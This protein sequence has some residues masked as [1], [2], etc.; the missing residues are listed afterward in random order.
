MDFILSAIPLERM[1]IG[2]AEVAPEIE[3]A[4][5]VGVVLTVQQIVDAE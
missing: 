3:V 2:Q 1:R 5:T 4:V